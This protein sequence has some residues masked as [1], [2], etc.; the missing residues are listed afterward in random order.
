MAQSGG[1]TIRGVYRYPVKGLSPEPLERVELKAGET[2]P[3]DRAYAIE[4]GPGRFD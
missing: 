1:P 3:F 2:V 4:N